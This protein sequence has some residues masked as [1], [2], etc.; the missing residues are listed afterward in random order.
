MYRYGGKLKLAKF[1]QDNMLL[2][3]NKWKSE[4]P[5]DKFYFRGYGEVN[6]KMGDNGKNKELLDVAMLE[7]MDMDV[8]DFVKS[9]LKS[10]GVNADEDDEDDDTNDDVK[11]SKMST[12]ERLLF[13]HQSKEQKALMERYGNHLSLL[14]ATWKTT[15][16]VLPL[17][18]L[19]VKT[20][21]IYQ[22]IG[23]FVIQDE[24]GPSILE[25]LSI[26]KKWNPDWSPNVVI[27]DNCNQE[28][29]A[30]KQLFPDAVILLCKFHREQSWNRWLN[31]SKNG[32]TQSKDE[33]LALLRGVADSLDAK[34]L[35]KNLEKLV[36]SD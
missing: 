22:L 29:N 25:A 6:K 9:L 21:T 14:D 28:I 34:S 5:D 17:F 7:F 33:A 16:Y 23:E 11:P 19:A 32:L 13:V 1:D 24:T 35:K 12:S 36:T 2:L 30:F 31:A 18:F 4:K 27:V 20:N 26:L 3:V 10:V 8:G 15:K